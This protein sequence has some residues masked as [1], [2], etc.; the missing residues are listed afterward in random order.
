MGKRGGGNAGGNA[1]ARA[2]V[3]GRTLVTE[4]ALE[5]RL[6]TAGGGRDAA[7]RR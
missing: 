1:A 5:G 3:G 6:G 4:S 2:G 7:A